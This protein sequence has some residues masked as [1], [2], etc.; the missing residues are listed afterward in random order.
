MSHMTLH[1]LCC[2]SSRDQNRAERGVDPLRHR[3]RNTRQNG[4]EMRVL[5]LVGP[6]PRLNSKY[7]QKT[8]LFSVHTG[9]AY[10]PLNINFNGVH[11]KLKIEGLEISVE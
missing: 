8:H 1:S 11:M 3:S 4:G 5:G 7:T 6:M 9:Q 2:K 10:S